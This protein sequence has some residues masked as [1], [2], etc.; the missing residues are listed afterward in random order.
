[1]NSLKQTRSKIFLLNI[2]FLVL[3]ICS[4]S[5]NSD[6][7]SSVKIGKITKE[8]FREN[9]TKKG[10]I[11]TIEINSEDYEKL[12]FL[13]LNGDSKLKSSLWINDGRYDFEEVNSVNLRFGSDSVMFFEN[14]IYRPGLGSIDSLKLHK[15]L[16]I[17]KSWYG[18]PNLIFSDSKYLSDILSVIE[19]NNQR[20]IDSKKG[21]LAA[22]FDIRY[23]I[24]TYLLWEKDDFNLMI[25]YRKNS[26]DSLYSNNFIRYETTNFKQLIEEKRKEILQEATL[27]EYINLEFNLNPFTEGD[28]PYTDRL[29]LYIYSLRHDL[30][31]EVRN[32]RKFKFDVTF[33]DEYSEV[34]LELSDLD[35]DLDSPLISPSD[36][37]YRTKSQGYTISLDYSRLRSDTKDFENLRK[38]RER[39]IDKSNFSDIKIKHT[40]TAIIFE[41]GEV[42]K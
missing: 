39:K 33:E 41:S 2:L 27:N 14:L 35:L 6:P 4:C 36:G 10:I 18:E 29:N 5:N 32:I 42:L 1:M 34:I 3:L 24:N 7:I 28:Y 26:D 11:E 20:K 38:L 19:A 16:N 31:E 23:G 40:I 13:D 8:N 17:Y 30:P 37:L 21:P 22:A 25:S 9:L 15:V 12:M